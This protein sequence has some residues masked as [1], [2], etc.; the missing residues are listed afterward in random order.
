MLYYNDTFT[1]TLI[2]LCGC[3]LA[4]VVE[5]QVDVI[6]SRKDAEIARLREEIDRLNDEVIKPV[7]LDLTHDEIIIIQQI[8]DGAEI[9]EIIEFSQNTV[10]SKL[11]EARL[12]N[13]IDKNWE[14][15]ARYKSSQ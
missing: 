1:H 13:G 11:K 8:A 14:L 10:Y 4:L 6:L 9:K 15:I 5:H 7:P 3:V 2:H 12:R